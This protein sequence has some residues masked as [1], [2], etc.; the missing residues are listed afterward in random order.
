VKRYYG[1]IC[2]GKPGHGFHADLNPR[3]PFGV[4]GGWARGGRSFLADVN[5]PLGEPSRIYLRSPGWHLTIGLL[6]WH[7]FVET[8]RVRA[9]RGTQVNGY[10]RRCRPRLVTMMSRGRYRWIAFERASSEVVGG[11]S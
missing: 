10:Y 4:S 5:A 9:G 1:A 6:G 2:L 7:E 11:K 3:F 8:G